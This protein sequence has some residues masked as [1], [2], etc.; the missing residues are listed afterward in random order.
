MADIREI[1]PADGQYPKLLA[2]IADPPAVLYCRGDVSLLDSFCI[3]VVGTRNM[4][5][6]GR[7]A[8]ADLAGGLA[9]AGVTV[10]SGLALGVDAVAHTATLDACG[11]TI[12]VLG[13][14]IGLL[15]PSSN[16]A[17]GERIIA[18]G[19]LV[20]SEYPGTTPGGQYTF[21]MR[22][23][24]ISGLSR[25]VLVVEADRRS[26]SLITAEAALDQDRDVWAV[27]GSIYW[28]RSVGANWLIGQGARPATTAHDIL[29]HYRLTAAQPDLDLAPAPQVS[30]DD[31]VQ[32]R[33]L[34]L[35]RER[36]PTHLET[37]TADATHDAAR[38]MAAVALLELKGVIRHA[39]AGIYQV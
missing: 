35:L 4:S 11:K 38:V 37:L 5:D 32:A 7:Q 2:R 13:T 19:G 25:G 20:V 27:P 9:A 14:G 17:L 24:I 28:P 33:I 21:P 16:A 34:A 15:S 30:T 31:P 18:E 8:A 23:R 29:E 10:V 22:N 3:A 6:Y 26:G 1:R 39:G 36:G 12:A